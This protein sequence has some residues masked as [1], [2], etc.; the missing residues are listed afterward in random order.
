MCLSLFQNLC[1]TIYEFKTHCWEIS[2][3]IPLKTV[4]TITPMN[5]N[6]NLRYTCQ[7][8]HN[9]SLNLYKYFVEFI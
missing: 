3:H 9:F 8:V 6:T 2:N 1:L 5:F 7:F 4:I